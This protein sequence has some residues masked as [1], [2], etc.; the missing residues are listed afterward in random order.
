M[1]R[2]PRSCAAASARAASGGHDERRSATAVRADAEQ[3]ARAVDRWA[4]ASRDAST[5]SMSVDA[6][7]P[8]ATRRTSA[9][10]GVADVGRGVEADGNAVAC[11]V[12]ERRAAS[13][14]DGGARRVA[15]QRHGH[16]GRVD[17][18]APAPRSVPRSSTDEH[19][20]ELRRAPGRRALRRR[21]QA[22][23]A[24]LRERAP[25]ARDPA[26]SAFVHAARTRSGGHSRLRS[27]ARGVAHRD[28]LVGE[29]E[30]HAVTC[31]AGRAGARR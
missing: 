16:G 4:A 2:A 31:A 6:R 17:E 3:A 20:I 21:R 5:R 10:V 14:R 25:T 29:C 30:A 8:A 27:V 23:D 22:D 13:V 15:E 28:L 9:T 18:R 12:G 7:R 1:A 24:E 11:P 19:E 26:A